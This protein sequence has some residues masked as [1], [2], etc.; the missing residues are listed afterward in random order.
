[1][2]TTHLNLSWLLLVLLSLPVVEIF[3]LIQMVSGFGF[4]ITLGLLLGSALLG[5]YLLRNQ[6]WMTWMRV[7]EALQ[8]GE[9]PTEE[10]LNGS[11]IALGGGLLLFPGFLSD[12]IAL[13]CLVPITRKIL[14]RFII[15]NGAI[16]TNINGQTEIRKQQGIIEGEFRRDE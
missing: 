9:V 15:K 1:M 6:G 4:L 3:L 5:G 14:V 12:I 10:L 2:N 13:F 16:N 8:K 7:N 11:M